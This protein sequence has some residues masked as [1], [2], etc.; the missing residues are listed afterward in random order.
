MGQYSVPND[1]RRS[2]L[3]RLV[4][5]RSATLRGCKTPAQSIVIRDL[6]LTGLGARAE[7]KTP[8]FGEAVIVTIDSIGDLPA[9]VKW[10]SR[11]LF[12][13]HFSSTLSKT[14]LQALRAIWGQV[15]SDWTEA[16]RPRK[17]ASAKASAL[18]A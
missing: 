18:S 8:L 17:S 11:D 12:G 13:L 1:D 16:R 3:P 7:A 2:V 5:F 14:Q 6:S 9:I 15:H 10:V 4:G